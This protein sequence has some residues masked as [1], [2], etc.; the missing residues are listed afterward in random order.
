[1]RPLFPH[2]FVAALLAAL[3]PAALAADSGNAGLIPK[4]VNLKTSG[5][6]KPGV[7]RRA[8]DGKLYL[9][10]PPSKSIEPGVAVAGTSVRLHWSAPRFRVDGKRLKHLAGYRILYGPQRGHYTKTIDVGDHTSYTLRGL[11]PGRTY[12]IAVTAY[13]PS[14]IESGPS[15]EVKVVIK[16]S[17]S[18][19]AP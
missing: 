13:L 4:D 14:G 9:A 2:V 6:W 1:M 8:P 12:Y 7:I 11:A 17:A 3:S 10:K 16:K 18:E 19:A 15:N 5:N